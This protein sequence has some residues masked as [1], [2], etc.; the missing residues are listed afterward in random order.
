MNLTQSPIQ[1]CTSSAAETAE[2]GAAIAGLARRGDL[3]LLVGDL[4]SGKTVLAQGFARGLSV[5]GPV[6]S[7]TFTLAHRYPGRLIVNHLDV[8]RLDRL[9]EL[10]DL[11]LGELL[12]EG[13]TLVEWGDAVVAALPPDFL[14]LRIGFGAGDDQR[15]FELQLV[16]NGW[17]GRWPALAA[18]MKAWAC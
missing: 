13:V 17:V 14:E 8:Y 3:V 7:P 2:L 15:V 9:G 10:V 11:G 12:D 4:G 18:A 6:T 5:E 1:A 16:G